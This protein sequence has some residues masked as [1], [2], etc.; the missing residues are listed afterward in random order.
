ME[1]S[2]LWFRS[3]IRGV[4]LL[5]FTGAGLLAHTIYLGYH[6]Y[7]SS[8]AHVAPLSSAQAYYYCGAWLVAGLYLYAC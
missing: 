8:L 4:V 6:A 5:A 3:G 2:R 7:Q 1:L